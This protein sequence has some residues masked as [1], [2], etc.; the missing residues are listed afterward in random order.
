MKLN[1]TK[2]TLL[3][4]SGLCVA[5]FAFFVVAQENPSN[6][7]NIFLDSD[8]DGLSDD[9]ERAYGTDANNKDTDGDSYTDGVEVKSGYDPLKPAPGDKIINNTK[10]LTTNNLQQDGD[11]VNLTQEVSEEVANLITQKAGENQEIALEDLD[12]IIQKTTGETLTFD[13][14]PEVNESEIKIKEQNYSR[15]SDEKRAEKE[16]E[17]AL[18][19]LTA[20][21]YILV[22]NSPQKISATEDINKI[23]EDIISHTTSLSA[24]LADI[25]YFEDLA[26]KGET[27]L[28]QLKEIEVPESLVDLHINGLK[29]A[30]YAVSLKDEVKID[31]NDPVAT[32]ANLSK[33]QNLIN[34]TLELSEKVS[35]EFSKLGITE[36][37]VEL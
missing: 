6:D 21:S 4:F 37:P 29:L 16:K 1:H 20:I 19:Y 15:L 30:K 13:D 34:L 14:L 11:E 8:Q 33:V 36:I 22:N 25:S 31:S 10:Q 24:N 3:I 26:V 18:E 9:E 32:I 7:K 17:D 28:E 2:L 5:S 35:G 12:A 23:A 27:I